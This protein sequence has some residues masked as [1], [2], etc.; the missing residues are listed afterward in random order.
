ML[1]NSNSLILVVFI[2]LQLELEIVKIRFKLMLYIG[3]D[4]S[5]NETAQY[6]IIANETLQYFNVAVYR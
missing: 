6:G 5:K 1:C 2:Y 3:L 4:T